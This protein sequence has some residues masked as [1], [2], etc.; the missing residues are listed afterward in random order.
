MAREARRRRGAELPAPEAGA[1]IRIWADLHFDDERIWRV[2]ERPWPAV[3]PMNTALRRNWCES[4]G[5][6]SYDGVRG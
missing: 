1:E 3:E 5:S 2:A 4:S 6:G